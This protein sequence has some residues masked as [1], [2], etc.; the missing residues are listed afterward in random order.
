MEKIKSFLEKNL[1]ISIP[2]EWIFVNREK[3]IIEAMKCF[4]QTLWTQ[5]KSQSSWQ[6]KRT[7]F[8]DQMFGSGKTYFGRNLISKAKD[9]KK[10]IEKT[11]DELIESSRFFEGFKEWY[12]KI[13]ERILSCETK[14]KMYHKDIQNDLEIIFKEK[15]DIFIHIDELSG[16]E[17]EVRDLWKF[18]NSKQA[19]LIDEDQILIFFLSGKNTLMNKVN[20]L[21][22]K[23]W[24]K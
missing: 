6:L 1:G 18:L 8:S 20:L 22:I 4:I 10:D 19:N 5:K 17:T 11:L 24:Y 23:D 12:P 9:L 15:K 7:I 2:Q 13:L 3:E 14:T 16:N 21:L